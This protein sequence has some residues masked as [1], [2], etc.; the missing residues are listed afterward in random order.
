[1]DDA[2]GVAGKLALVTGA[3]RGIGAAIARRLAS[4]GCELLLVGRSENALAAVAREIGKS[5]GSA[6]CISV[7]LGDAEQTAELVQAVREKYG[8]LDVLVNNAGIAEPASLSETSVEM[9]DRHMAVNARAPFVLSSRFTDL[10][11]RSADGVIVNI[12]SVV[13]HKGYVN[14]GAYAASKHAMLGLTKV[15]A[16]ELHPRGVR[17]HLVSPGG[18][19][20][21]M[22]SGVRPDIDLSELMDP[23]EVAK[24]VE[25]LIGMDGVATVDEIAVRRRQSEPWK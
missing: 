12:G 24:V 14:Q 15:L 22:I 18:V 17:V 11:A 25:F 21:D 5:G 6:G 23:E 7:D 1:M 10:L 2:Q 13:S 20:T 16:R 9:W 4:A 3:S 8:R 19:A